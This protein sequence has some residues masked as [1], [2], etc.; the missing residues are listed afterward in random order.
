MP[1]LLDMT[2]SLNGHVGRDDGSDPGLDDWYFDPS[3]ISSR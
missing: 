2:I 3:E 1:V